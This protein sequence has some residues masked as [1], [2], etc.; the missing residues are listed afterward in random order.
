MRSL[1]LAEVEGCAAVVVRG[2]PRRCEKEGEHVG[3]AHARRA[4]QHLHERDQPDG[5]L[6]RNSG[7]AHLSRVTRVTRTFP[8]QM[9]GYNKL[10]YV[11]QTNF[12]GLK[13]EIGRTSN[14]FIIERICW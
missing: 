4:E 8:L 1:L 5:R 6:Q 2:H 10:R 3:D 7:G 14:E 13:K 9:Y 11:S 12:H